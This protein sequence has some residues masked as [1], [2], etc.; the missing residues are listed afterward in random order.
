V[1]DYTPAAPASQKMK[2]GDGPTT[3]T[4]HRTRDILGELGKLPSR[5]QRTPVLVGFAAETT[6]IVAYAQSKL[7]QK[8]ADLI[9][10]NDVSRS[11]A[12]FDV[13]T[14]A[15]TLVSAAGAEAL[16][17]QSK[18]AVAQHILDRIEQFLIAVPAKDAKVKA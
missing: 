10:A 5:K 6:D 13:D 4:L 8:A 12:G 2:K 9:V 17:V 3:I 1:A 14:N 18:A 11:D 15:V 7:Q 16:P